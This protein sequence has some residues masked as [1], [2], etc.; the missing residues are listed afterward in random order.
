MLSPLLSWA[1]KRCREEGIH[2]LVNVGRW[3]EEGEL[4]EAIAPYRR[5]L[6]TSWAYFYRANNPGLAERLRDRRAWAPS[7]FD[8]NASL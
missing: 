1:L 4:I 7:L 6:T 5:K 8:G 3:L 2:M